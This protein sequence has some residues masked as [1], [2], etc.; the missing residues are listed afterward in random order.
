MQIP[1]GRD[2]KFVAAVILA[3]LGIIL[4]LLYIYASGD[5]LSFFLMLFMVVVPGG[6]GYV[7]VGMKTGTLHKPEIVERV[8]EVVG[9]AG[10]K[11]LESKNF[12]KTRKINGV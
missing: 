5:E 3:T 6:A 10:E 4:N 9:L 1:D 2:P 11:K 8:E 7:I 12:Y